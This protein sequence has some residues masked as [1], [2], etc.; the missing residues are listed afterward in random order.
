MNQQKINTPSGE[1][2]VIREQTGADDDLLSRLDVDEATTLNRY[3]AAIVEA[4]PNGK[5][6]T[7]ADVEKLLLRDKY[8]ILFKSRIFSLSE[9]LIFGYTWDP[10][11]EPIEYVVDL[12]DYIW[13][14]SKPLP[15]L[16]DEDYSRHRILP[17]AI[18]DRVVT[19]DLSSGKTVSFEYLDGI[20]EKYLLAVKPT[21]RSINKQL[22]ARAFKYN[23]GSKMVIVKNFQA[24]SSRDMMEIRNKVDQLDP[25]LTGTTSI[26]NPNT[27]E[28]IDLP[29]IAIKDF[30]YPVKI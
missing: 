5:R 29:I 2:Y 21:E 8:A 24:F 1:T 20:G 30:Y 17:Y 13:D 7:L 15:V 11:E 22:I 14:Y 27:G 23:D 6:L 28:K 19:F 10:E 9:N 3:I 16:G 18:A 12:N 4:A 25:A 26:E